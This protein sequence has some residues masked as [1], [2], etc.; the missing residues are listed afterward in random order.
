MANLLDRIDRATSGRCP[1]GAA[2]ADGSAYCSDDCRPSHVGDDT[3]TR[4][5]GHLA[6]PMRWRPDLVTAGHDDDLVSLGIETCYQGPYQARIFERAD[7]P[8]S[9]HLRLDDGHRYV[10]CD[11][12][13]VGPGPDPVPAHLVGRLRDAWRRLERELTDPR[14]TVPYAGPWQ[15]AFPAPTGPSV[16][17]AFGPAQLSGAALAPWRRLCR[18]CDRHGAPLDGRRGDEACQ[19]CAHC[20]APFPGPPLVPTLQS[21]GRHTVLKLSYFANGEYFT[22]SAFVPGRDMMTAEDPA[23]LLQSAWDRLETFVLEQIP[24]APAG[25]PGP[26]AG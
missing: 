14:R 2:P 6:T 17:D 25:P 3:D 20:R 26:A 23:A 1:C 7:R 8:G 11:L 16:A 22:R 4:E 5:A 10:G 12:G 13:D 19:L 15:A 9:W 18:R 21:H 24:P